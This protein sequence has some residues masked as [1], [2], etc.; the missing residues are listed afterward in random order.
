MRSRKSFSE[1]LSR[2]LITLALPFLLLTSACSSHQPVPMG[3]IPEPQVPQIEHVKM[4]LRAAVAHEAKKGRKLHRGCASYKRTKQILDR[5]TD[6]VG[7]SRDTWPLYMV[8]AGENANAF[9]VNQNTILV[10][11]GLVRRLKDDAELATIIAHEVAHIIAKH[12]P[13]E[14]QDTKAFAAKLGAQIFGIAA[15]IGS[16]YAGMDGQTAGRIGSLTT[17]A[18]G[19]VG[20]GLM[21]QYDRDQEYEADQI[22]L[23]IMSKAG[24]NPQ[25]AISLWKKT[26]EVFGSTNSF[27]FF[28]THPSD[29][30]RIENLE[31]AL[32]IAQNYYVE[33]KQK[34]LAGRK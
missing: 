5:L 31:E 11:E 16:A 22:G 13:D 4:T 1:C 20:S 29:D 34:R 28:S 32:P 23:M 7:A 17:R 10:Y 14:G 15:T 27:S 33:S 8:E 19:A 12:K 25:S 3:S 30:A 9:A 26:D 24:Y 21:L 18:T 2:Q 6:A